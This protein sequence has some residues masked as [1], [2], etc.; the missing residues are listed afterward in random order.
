MYIW[1]L[2]RVK[3]AIISFAWGP[4]SLKIREILAF[5]AATKLH[6]HTGDRA[7]MQNAGPKA[8]E[9][10]PYHS[11]LV[12]FSH[13][14][15]SENPLWANIRPNIRCLTAMLW[16]APTRRQL[17]LRQVTERELCADCHHGILFSCQLIEYSGSQCTCWTPG[18]DGKL[19]TH[20][21]NYWFHSTRHT[22]WLYILRLI[23]RASTLLEQIGKERSWSDEQIDCD[24]AVLEKNRLYYVTTESFCIFGKEKTAYPI[25]FAIIGTRP[26]STL[27]P[28]LECK[29]IDHMVV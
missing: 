1:I 11:P 18:L 15:F 12:I 4:C 21:V 27:E 19:S 25:H 2:A 24:L 9:T 16:P 28:E 6:E 29:R 23:Q 17:L 8:P 7:C 20:T 5:F 14:Y 10:R 22:D 13:S 3:S 26:S